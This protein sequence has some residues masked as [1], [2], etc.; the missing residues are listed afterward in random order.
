M[1][2]KI[3]FLSAGLLVG[4]LALTDAPVFAQSISTQTEADTDEIESVEV[5]G[6]RPCK[7]GEAA[8]AAQVLQDAANK[9]LAEKPVP[10]TQT[11]GPGSA[12]I[13]TGIGSETALKQRL[14][15]NYGVSV[16]PPRPVRSF[17]QSRR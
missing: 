9:A 14:H 12:D 15:T 8:C 10:N 6:K 17:P 16:Q 2:V 1:T 4:A 11:H 13:H 5:I 7:P 3:R